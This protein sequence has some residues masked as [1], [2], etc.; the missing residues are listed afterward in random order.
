MKAGSIVDTST[1]SGHSSTLILN[2]GSIV[3]TAG[4]P[5]GGQFFPA[6]SSTKVYVDPGGAVF[7]NGGFNITIAQPLT[8]ASNG[9]LTSLGAGTT[10]LL[11]ANTYTGATTVNGGTL[12]IGTLAALPANNSVTLNAAMQLAS[13]IGAPSI[14]SL[15][16]G[17]AGTL[18]VTNNSVLINY[19]VAADPIAAIQTDLANGYSG[20]A[21][22]GPGIISSTVA[23][24]NSSSSLRYA[25]GYIDGATPPVNYSGTAPASGTIEI[26][27]T[28]AGD[29]TLSGT[30]N[31]YDFQLVLSNFGMSN[32]SWD[33][34]DFDYTGTVDF[35]DFQVVLSNFGQSSTAL[36]SSELATL[37]NFAAKF[38]EQVES[39]LSLV[40]VPEPASAS[41][42]LLGITC[43]ARRRR[44]KQ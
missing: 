29:A 24:L 27:P 12:V 37:N 10:T 15:T 42:A 44:R 28:L 3:A 40:S 20:G 16:L 4:D 31:F 23:G 22:T 6:L 32:Q 39:N 25:L 14:S 19:G 34:G 2:G 26:L 30:V 5:A 17:A 7:N 36:S 35:Y 18:D 9:G 13:G 8:S 38:G 43:L 21:W 1:A 33:Q 11:G 41:L